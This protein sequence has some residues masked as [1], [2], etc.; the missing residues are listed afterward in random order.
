MVQS[1]HAHGFRVIM[2]VVYN[3]TYSLDSPFSRVV[4]GYYYRTDAQGRPSNGSA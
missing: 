1:L 4:P 3:H 2:D